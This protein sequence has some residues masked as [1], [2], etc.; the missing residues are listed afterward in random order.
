M[1]I[2]A[3]AAAPTSRVVSRIASSLLWTLIG[4]EIMSAASCSD[5]SRLRASAVSHS[6]CSSTWSRKT[7]TCGSLGA[8][9]RAV[10]SAARVAFCADWTEAR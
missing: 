9:P 6:R 8:N 4:C 3:S 2:T 10:S 5:C 7:D 1:L